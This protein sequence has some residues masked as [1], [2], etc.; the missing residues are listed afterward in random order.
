MDD[1]GREAFITL[2]VENARFAS[3]ISVSTQHNDFAPD[4]DYGNRGRI[5]V[6][7]RI[8]GR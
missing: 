5:T 1:D 4:L 3:T 6:E 2:P 8:V 7:R